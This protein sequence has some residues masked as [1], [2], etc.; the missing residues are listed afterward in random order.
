MRIHLKH[1]KE[2][3]C[4]KN[5]NENVSCDHCLHSRSASRCWIPAG[6]TLPEQQKGL[7]ATVLSSRPGW[8]VGWSRPTVQKRVVVPEVILPDRKEPNR[9]AFWGVC[10]FLF[11]PPFHPSFFPPPTSYLSKPQNSGLP[12]RCQGSWEPSCEMMRNHAKA[13][14]FDPIHSIVSN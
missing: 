7:L 5:T 9:R 10:Y 8:G 4:V 6:Y 13:L 12:G 14:L 2:A 1:F 11:L 3:Q